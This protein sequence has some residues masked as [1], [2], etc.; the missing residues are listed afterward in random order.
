ML[1]FTNLYDE[2]T[3]AIMT[4]NRVTPLLR[5]ALLPTLAVAAVAIAASTA[6]AGT[7][8]L[9][10]ALLGAAVVITFSGGGLLALRAVRQMY[11]EVV[12]L[13]AV[14]SYVLRV[15]IFGV[16]LALVGSLNGVD[17]VVHRTATALTVLVCVVAWLAGELRAFVRMRVPLYD[18]D[19]PAVRAASARRNGRPGGA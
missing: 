17:S 19:D 3:A 18:L 10:G 9:V 8:G 6:F 15:V 5:G 12:L 16:L 2:G 4:T 7:R 13:V 14:G 1:S 11:P